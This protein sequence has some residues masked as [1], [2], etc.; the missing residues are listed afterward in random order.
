MKTDL[1]NK[2]AIITG[3]SGGIGKAICL[4]LAKHGMNLVLVGRNEIKLLET[5]EAAEELGAKTFLCRGDI[6]DLTFTQ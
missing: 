6:R 2:T 5:K 3:A 4:A 1:T